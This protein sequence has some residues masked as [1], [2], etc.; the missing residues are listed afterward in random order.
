MQ[1]KSISTQTKVLLI[2][3]CV[4][5]VV[6]FTSHKSSAQEDEINVLYVSEPVEDWRDDSF[7]TA[8]D[9]DPIFSL[10]HSTPNST[11]F[12]SYSSG[13]ELL[14][15]YDL[16]CLLDV[17]LSL[18]NRTI[19]REYVIAGGALIIMCGNNITASPD[20]FVSLDII[21]SNDSSNVAVNN[22]VALSSGTNSSS[23]L[24]DNIDW[25]SCPAVE[26]YT[27]FG[28][29][30]DSSFSGDSLIV[31]SP[32]DDSTVTSLDPLVFTKN[33]GAGTVGVITY[34]LEGQDNIQFLIWAY[35][36]YFAYSFTWITLNQPEKVESFAS[37]KYSPVPHRLSQI[38][39]TSIMA[40]LVFFTMFAIIKIRRHSNKTRETLTEISFEENNNQNGGQV[41]KKSNRKKLFR[42]RKMKKEEITDWEEVGFHRQLSGFFTAF[43]ISV[44]FG[45]PQLIMAF[46]V[47]PRFINPFPLAQGNYNFTLKTFDAIW[48]VLDLGTTVS[49]VK[50]FSEY[51]IDNPKKA[52]RY[53][54]IFTFW[55]LI[56]GVGQF[57]T[58][59]IISLWIIPNT[60]LAHFSWFFLFHSMIQFP[61]FLAIMAI[62]FQGNQRFDLHQIL[63]LLGN[64][65]AVLITQYGGILLF[66][67]IFRNIPQF[68]ESFGA[69]LGYMVGS[70][71]AGFLTFS[72]GIAL[73][74]KKFSQDLKISRI[75]FRI[76]FKWK[77]FKQVLKF[78]VILVLGNVFV[79]LVW[80]IQTFLVSRH[81]IDYSSEIA[82]FEL[83]LTIIGILS[84]VGIFFTGSLPG[85]SEATGNKKYKLRDYVY[86]QNLRWGNLLL[87]F[88]GGFLYVVGPMIIQFSGSSWERAQIFF[89]GWLLHG[90]LGPPS[91]FADKVFQQ[92]ENAVKYNTWMWIL[93]QGIRLILLLI[94]VP[95][96]KSMK[97][98]IWAYNPALLAKDIISFIIIRYKMKIRPK[99]YWWKVWIAPLISGLLS[100][101]VFY[102]TSQ[103]FGEI[104]TVKTILIF[105]MGFLVSQPLYYI[106]LGYFGA[107]DPNSL[108]EFNKGTKMVVP[109]VR[110]LARI[111]YWAVYFGAIVLKSPL[112]ERYTIDIYDE[113]MKEAKEL[114]EQKRV[115]EY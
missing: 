110:V 88:L 54:Q 93:E 38:I 5:S 48:L 86:I 55:Q 72:F 85:M 17:V 4:I 97:A 62:F 53:M 20:I 31:K 73:F 103:L 69:T 90:I 33:I 60:T 32:R 76:D 30:L 11:N 113:A 92:D 112:H 25:N 89:L 78:G 63:E 29:T 101:G 43:I 84:L 3:V 2:I 26:N 107:F 51:R 10:N 39:L 7:Q 56:T 83:T 74:K 9:L 34:W 109:G 50:Y 77:E 80:T 57:A 45:I 111:L 79:P 27:S 66:R 1:T 19:L 8:L 47:F 21:E 24:E 58:V 64:I 81:V 41:K 115:L 70:W 49:V 52:I 71:I 37:W 96:M 82:Y 12:T 75:F 40:L 35:Y 106:F 14:L 94:L 98:V 16:I 99:R 15:E 6:F 87:F 68:G 59:S 91:W 44:I 22:E 42:P 108:E 61:G 18:A 28:K 67:F 23:P 105:M 36:N 13:S 95:A 114:T 100:F 104:T 65:F 102:G 46:Y